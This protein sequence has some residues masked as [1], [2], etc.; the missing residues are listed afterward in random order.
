MMAAAAMSATLAITA[1]AASAAA[2]TLSDPFYTYTGTTPLAS[3]PPGTV[4]KTRNVTYHVAGIPTA[5]TAQQL[6]YRTHNALNQPVVNVTSVIR[7]GQQR[8]GH[9]VPVGLRFA[10][11]VRR[12]VAGDRRRS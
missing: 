11:P 2:P 7:L 5:L 6:L 4:L 8:L 9:L 10:E 1:P 12:A 3:I